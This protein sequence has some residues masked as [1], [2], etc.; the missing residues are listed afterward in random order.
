MVVKHAHQSEMIL[1]FINAPDVDV[2]R[3]K[4]SGVYI[5]TTKINR[6]MKTEHI[7]MRG[8]HNNKAYKY[9]KYNFEIGKV[10]FS[11]KT[12]FSLK[13]GDTVTVLLEDGEK[14]LKRIG[15]HNHRTNQYQFLDS[16]SGPILTTLVSLGT[17][18]ITYSVL[19]YFPL[20]SWPLALIIP[21]Q[22]AKLMI[23]QYK[24]LYK[25]SAFLKLFI[26]NK[27]SYQSAD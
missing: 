1:N 13:N 5:I 12:D 18:Y 23:N 16:Y 26:R 22:F 8:K 21:Y 17:V 15:Y 20:I 9:F 3:D 27:A 11:I 4:L 25:Q 14:D 10:P 6:V 2:I 19:I 24:G 7:G